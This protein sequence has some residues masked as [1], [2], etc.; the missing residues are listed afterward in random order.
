MSLISIYNPLSIP[1]PMHVPFVR[2]LGG[3]VMMK[4][5][6]FVEI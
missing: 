5:L 4:K 6:A 1:L 3:S 2:E